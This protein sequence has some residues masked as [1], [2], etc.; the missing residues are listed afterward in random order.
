MGL[1]N[2]IVMICTTAICLGLPIIL[3]K[4]GIPV[5]KKLLP[6][7]L[8][9]IVVMTAVCL[10]FT[11]I[12]RVDTGDPISSFADVSN[13]FSRNFPTIWTASWIV[14]AIPFAL[15]LTMLCYLD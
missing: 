14:K 6:S 1:L 4:V 10:A 12:K 15:N 7:T 3:G 8:V 11:D 13:L 5:L 2:F 9:A